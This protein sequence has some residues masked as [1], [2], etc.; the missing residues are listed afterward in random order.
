[1]RFLSVIIAFALCSL[2]NTAA[3]PPGNSL[4]SLRVTR[5]QDPNR[6]RGDPISDLLGGLLGGTGTG[7]DHVSDLL[8]GLL[9]AG[10]GSP[11]D[12][13]SSVTGAVPGLDSVTGSLGG[14][15]GAVPSLSGSG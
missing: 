9:G 8:G 11:L 3:L 4:D 10:G 13:L 7:G 14:V 5:R 1:M 15:T 6:K 12:S 2:G